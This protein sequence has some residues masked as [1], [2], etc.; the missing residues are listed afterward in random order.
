MLNLTEIKIEFCHF[1]QVFTNVRQSLTSL[2]ALQPHTSSLVSD[3]VNQVLTIIRSENERII[4][5]L[6]EKISH[7]SQELNK[8]II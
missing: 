6:F 1:L 2:V 5:V 3:D 4:S 7:L 8:V